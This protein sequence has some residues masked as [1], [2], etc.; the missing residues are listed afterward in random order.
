LIDSSGNDTNQSQH[1]KNAW[2]QIPNREVDTNHFFMNN[3]QARLTLHQSVRSMEVEQCVI[4]INNFFTI[5]QKNCNIN[6]LFYFELKNNKVYFEA[7][8][9]HINC[10]LVFQNKLN[11]WLLK[12]LFSPYILRICLF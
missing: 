2:L 12:V 10:Y 6:R 7:L 8:L 11:K 4:A 5:K 1:D 9:L 3:S